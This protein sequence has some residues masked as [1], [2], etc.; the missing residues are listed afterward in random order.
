ML[1]ATILNRADAQDANQ[2]EEHRKPML[3][4]PRS[5]RSSKANRYERGSKF[6]DN[7]KKVN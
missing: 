4:G 7:K 3:C 6:T 1:L 5:Y 2:Q